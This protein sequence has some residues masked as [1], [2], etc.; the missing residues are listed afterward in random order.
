M[1][2]FLSWSGDHSRAVADA[3]NELLASV[4]KAVEP[5]FSPEIKKGKNW[6]LEIQSALQATRFGI[7]CLTPE[8]LNSPW[9]HYEAGALSKTRGALL[10]TFL[11]NLK[12]EDVPLPLGE[13]Q[14]TMARKDEVLDLLRTINS[15]LGEKHQRPLN[16]RQLKANFDSAWPRMEERLAA[17]EKNSASL[18]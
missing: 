12:H 2:V 1:K 14:H 10:W 4:I 16:D 17:I 7:V 8:N 5:F 3:L 18:I 13:F 6:T 9:L 11:H 15:Q